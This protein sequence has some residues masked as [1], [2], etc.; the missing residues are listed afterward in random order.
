ME[1]E[2]QRRLLALNRHF[3]ATIA[4]PFDQTRRSYP[5]GMVRLLEHIPEVGNRPLSVLDV[6]CGNGR[7]AAVL[8][9]MQRPVHYVGV[10]GDAQL[11][12]LA[13]ANTAHLHYTNSAFIQADL[14]EPGWHMALAKVYEQAEHHKFD[15][16]AC[17]ATLHHM[18]GYALRREVVATCAS[19]L[20][21]DGVFLLSTWQF[22]TSERFASRLIEWDVVGLTAAEVEEGDA[23]LPWKQGRYAVR[24]VHQIDL[25]EVE[26]LAQDTNLRIVSSYRADGKEGNL[27]LYTV[28][29]HAR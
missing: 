28:L 8:E 9:T 25:P 20:A 19:L 16:I 23:L 29:R 15:V 4:E 21:A 13:E 1:K 18:P 7:F 3:Y 26:K 14:A 24:Y 2:T 12:R 11:L 27:N 22:L 5:V 10:D 17:L 6:G